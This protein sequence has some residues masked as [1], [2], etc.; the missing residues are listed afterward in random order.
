MPSYYALLYASDYSNFKYTRGLAR[1]RQSNV[2]HKGHCHHLT[3]NHPTP[4]RCQRPAKGDNLQ[5]AI[6]EE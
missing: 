1:E 5:S 3:R 4:R 2:E 6:D